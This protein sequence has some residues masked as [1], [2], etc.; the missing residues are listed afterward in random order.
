M[1]SIET[2]NIA[3]LLAITLYSIFAEVCFAFWMPAFS[4]CPY[5]LQ[6][7]VQFLFIA[8]PQASIILLPQHIYLFYIG[9]SMF[10]FLGILMS[11]LRYEEYLTDLILFFKI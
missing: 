3:E 9:N 10:G 6:T 1:E 11:V 7:I 5:W 4:I 8:V 2:K